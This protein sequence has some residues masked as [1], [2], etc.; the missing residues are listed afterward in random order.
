CSI[1]VFTDVLDDFVIVRYLSSDAS[2]ET[3]SMRIYQVARAA[4][5]PALNAMASIILAVSAIVI[6]VGWLAYR[7]W[8]RRQG[9]NTDVSSL[10]NTL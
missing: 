4:P 6:V 9:E 10:A 2:T 5:T 7:R 8:T 3:T 1:L